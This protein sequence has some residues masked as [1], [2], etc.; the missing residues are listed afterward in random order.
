MNTDDQHNRRERLS[1]ARLYE[2]GEMRELRLAR[3]SDTA[4]KNIPDC[5]QL[6]EVVTVRTRKGLRRCVMGAHGPRV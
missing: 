3:I 4:Q 6:T 2:S 5:V 1:P